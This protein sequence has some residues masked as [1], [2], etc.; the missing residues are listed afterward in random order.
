MESK[1]TRP[2]WSRKE[3]AIVREVINTHKDKK[4]KEVIQILCDTLKRP[5]GSVRLKVYSLAPKSRFQRKPRKKVKIVPQPI[6][7]PLQIP[8]VDKSSA[9]KGKTNK[10]KGV[11]LEISNIKR[12]ILTDQNTLI[13]ELS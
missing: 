3:I 1:T 4:L 13:I 10:A 2:R 9:D 5:I 12:A 11:I 6:G 7:T 8:F